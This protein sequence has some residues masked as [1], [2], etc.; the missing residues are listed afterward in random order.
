MAN[1]TTVKLYIYDISFGLASAYGSSLLG[2]IC[3]FSL[4]LFIHFF[5][6]LRQT[7]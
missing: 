7:N 4:V 5:M 6:I 2:R 3:L 1:F